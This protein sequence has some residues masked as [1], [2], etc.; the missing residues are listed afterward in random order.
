MADTA[1]EQHRLGSYP[2]DIE[3]P[4]TPA[5][6]EPGG[7]LPVHGTLNFRDLGGYATANDQTVRRGHVYR[8][9]HLNE[10]TNEGLAEL[11]RL[12]IRTVVDLRF[13]GE[14]ERQP[15]R[16][17]EGTA[18]VLAHAEGMEAA[19][20]QGFLEM[21]ASAQVS[22]YHAEEAAADYRTMVNDGIGLVLS[23]LQT[24][25]NGENQPVLFHCTAGKDRTGIAAAML[26]R[27]LDVPD[28]IIMYDYL[29]TNRHR[30]IHRLNEMAPKVA[31]HGVSINDVY[32]MFVANRIALQA[33]LDEVDRQ[34]GTETFLVSRGLDP[35]VPA[36]LCH[37][38]V[39]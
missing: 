23:V 1:S 11:K 15:S 26:L 30:A 9:D 20:Q 2:A 21:I 32:G 28:E 17:P 38:L 29:L 36:Q 27:L 3:F 35:K 16:L 37:M 14:R 39:S 22:R 18:V 8:S 12:G 31:E 6:G 4:P 13:P 19:N 34:G 7:W 25:A 24:V 5:E 10:V 33:V